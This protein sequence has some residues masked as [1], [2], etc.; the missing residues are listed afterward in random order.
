MQDITNP[1]TP[2]TAELAV[3]NDE[4]QRREAIRREHLNHEASVKSVGMLYYL[5]AVVMFFVAVSILVAGIEQNQALEVVF[6]IVYLVLA[7]LFAPIGRGLR[8]LRSWV[9]IPVTILSAI[10][11]IGFPVGTIINGYIIYLVWSKK[12]GMVFSTPYHEIVEQTPHIKYRT[13]IVVWLLLALILIGI[14]AAILIP[15]FSSS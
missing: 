1:Y 4:T 13:S 8:K 3:D 5:S 2:P 12:G 10:G 15:A 9:K 11:L 7:F 14:L 6:A